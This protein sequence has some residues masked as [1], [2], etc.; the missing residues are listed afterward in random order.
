VQ[1]EGACG[2]HTSDHRCVSAVSVYTVLS[3]EGSSSG[4]L[5]RRYASRVSMWHRPAVIIEDPSSVVC[6][7][8][9]AS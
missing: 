9:T 2:E 7:R 8:S 1:T 6:A 5:G 4:G 3:R